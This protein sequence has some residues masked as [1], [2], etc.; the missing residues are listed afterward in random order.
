MLYKAFKY[1]LLILLLSSSFISCGKEDPSVNATRLR[2]KLTDAA[3]PVIKELHI[4]IQ[5]IEVVVAD[6]TASEGEWEPLQFTGGEYNLLTLMNGRSVQL[7][8]Q[9]FPAGGILRKIKMVLGNNNRILT[10]TGQMISLN[11]PS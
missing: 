5:R 6:T 2:I 10:T 3:S 11:L 9:Y 8:D 7:V 1:S 4:D